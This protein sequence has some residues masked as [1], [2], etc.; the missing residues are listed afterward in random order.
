M[1]KYQLTMNKT[2]K[3]RPTIMKTLKSKRL[4]NLYKN[5]LPTIQAFL[6]IPK[7]AK[8]TQN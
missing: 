5:L 4:L 1:A 6:S 8:E 3:S 7:S 2:N